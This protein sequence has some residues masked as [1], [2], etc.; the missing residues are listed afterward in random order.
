MTPNLNKVL[1]AAIFSSGG[2]FQIFSQEHLG[3]DALAPDEVRNFMLVDKEQGWP[4]LY[5]LVP[6]EFAVVKDD[7]LNTCGAI[8]SRGLKSV[9]DIDSSAHENVDLSDLSKEHLVYINNNGIGFI[10]LQ[11]EP[12]GEPPSM[13]K[14]VQMRFD[15]SRHIEP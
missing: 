12:K 3:A 7:W 6:D 10:I 11:S 13:I 15:L 5:I 4:H 9:L 14:V 1:L 8:I 2:L